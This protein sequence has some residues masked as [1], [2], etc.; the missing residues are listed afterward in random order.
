VSTRRFARAAFTSVEQVTEARQVLFSIGD[1]LVPNFASRVGTD[2]VLGL[3]L[4]ERALVEHETVVVIDN[5][6]SILADPASLDVILDLCAALGKAGQT[7]LIFTS[8]EALPAPFADNALRIGRLDRDTAIR[9]LGNLLP[10]APKSDESEE[11]LQN[12][13]DAVGGHARS[14]VLIAREVGAAGVRHATQN[15]RDVLQAIE[16]KHPGDRENSL[17]ASAELSLRRLPA[18]VRQLIR[19]LSVFQGGSGLPAIGLALKLNPVQLGAVVRA[20]IGVGL[21]EYVEPGYLR[22]DPALLGVDLGADEREI[23]IA[24]WAEAMAAE[25]HFLYEQQSE[26]SNLANN[27]ALLEL[28]NF[29]A[30]LTH[31]AGTESPEQVVNLATSMESIV[32]T[33]NRPKTLSRVVQLRI[34]AAERLP[35]WSHAQY[36]AVRASIERLIDQG[37]FSEAV[38][39][40]RTLHMKSDSAG[41]TAYDGAAY[42]GAMAQLTLGQALRLSGDSEA[43]LPH[44]EKGR[45]RFERLSEPRMACVAITGKADCLRDLGRYDEAAKAYEQAVRI[46]EELHDRRSAAVDKGQLATVRLLQKKYSEALALYAE[47][48]DVFEHL[49][50]PAAIAAAW[51]QIG[52]VYETAGGYDAAEDA[53][54]K[55]LNIEIQRGSLTGRADS[56]GQLGNLYSKMGRREDAVRLYRQAADIA[57]E[58]GNLSSEG[59]HRSNIANEFVRLNRYDEAR[60][61]I[62]RAIECKKPFGH[63]GQL[64]KPFTVLSNL[65]RAVGNQLAALQARDQA[66]TAYLA[67]RREGGAPEIDTTQLIEMV[68]QNPAAARA[69]LEDTDVPFRAAAEITLLLESLNTDQ[70]PALP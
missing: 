32:S 25:V 2:D 52:L 11:D 46:D 53:Y 19:P 70:P 45:L 56:L 68:K 54:Q 64:W 15:L 6:E 67:Y 63:A 42:D 26:D 44:V 38:R 9:L 29:L 50:E 13:V 57:A 24:A 34:S 60:L 41:E 21:A 39:S 62:R 66:L 7:R 14:L 69:A 47:A 1:Q 49:N 31:L 55:S 58:V 43:A 3:Q 40:A 51:H 61:E 4:L 48:R 20:L 27:L 17:L 22:F 35:E 23:L 37:R 30:A 5:V 33:L 28:P 59:S 65:E 36:L 18:E 12:L 16:A 8:R 10:N